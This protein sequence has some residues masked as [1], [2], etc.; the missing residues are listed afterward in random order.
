MANVSWRILLID[1]D[2]DD[3]LLVGKLLQSIERWSVHIVV[4]VSYL[5]GIEAIHQGSYDVILV[6]YDLG[7]KNG[8]ELIHEAT[9]LGCKAPMIMVSGRGRHEMDLKAVQAGASSY[10]TKSELNAKLL[11]HTIRFSIERKQ[12][13]EDL[14]KA[15]ALSSLHTV[16]GSTGD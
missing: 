8:I 15:N 7:P 10:L 4:A 2:E 6:D 1:D 3:Q 11:E 13:D 14:Q 12:A 16:L 5:S 9:A